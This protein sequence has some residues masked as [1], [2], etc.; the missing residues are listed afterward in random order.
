[1]TQF[2]KNVVKSFQ[3]VREDIV[4]MQ[5]RL[6]TLAHQ[7]NDIALRMQKALEKQAALE[8]KIKNKK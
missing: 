1:M 8:A 4:I 6:D 7:H 5:T 2:Q 3:K